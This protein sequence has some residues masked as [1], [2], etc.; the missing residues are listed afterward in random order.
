MILYIN[1][2]SVC[3][4][5]TELIQLNSVIYE[6]YAYIL[7]LY[8]GKVRFWCL[9]FHYSLMLS[10]PCG[11]KISRVTH[12]DERSSTWDG[13]FLPH[14]NEVGVIGSPGVQSGEMRNVA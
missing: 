5:S 14:T 12:L 7:Q 11:E 9:Q 6:M 3:Y 4:C 1:G 2:E 10:M 13:T 8:S